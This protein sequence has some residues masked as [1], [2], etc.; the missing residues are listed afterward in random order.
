[1]S[2]RK[3]ISE[4][5]EQMN[6]KLSSLD[7]KIASLNQNVLSIQS[8]LVNIESN[9]Q[10]YSEKL[11]F[12][13]SKI[14]IPVLVNDELNNLVLPD[15]KKKILIVGFYGAPNLGDE[16][17][18][19]TLLGY[20]QKY[21]NIAIT[22][23]LSNNPD[24][25]IFTYEKINFIHYPKTRF[26]YDKLSSLFDIVIFG[27]GAHI[28]DN[29]YNVQYNYKYQ[30]MSMSTTL[31]E[32]SKSMIDKNKKCYWVGLSSNNKLTNPDFIERLKYIVKH[33]NGI[34]LR[35]S[36][37]LD[38]LKKVGVDASQIKVID[39]I[40]FAN[41][42][43]S[44]D[45]DFKNNKK[46]VFGLILIFDDVLVKN[47]NKLIVKYL[48]N[49]LE[50]KQV[51]YKINLIPFYNYLEF[52][53][54][55]LNKIAEELNNKN[56][57][58]KDYVNNIDILRVLRENNYIISL[59]YHGSLLASALNI[60]LLTI[61]LNNH[62]HY[63][64]KMEY[65]YKNYN[66]TNNTLNINEVNQEFLNKAFDKLLTTKYIEVDKSVFINSQNELASI[67]DKIVN[68]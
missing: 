18:L 55:N 16:L 23:M 4:E 40:V 2:K 1:M 31:I 8:Q 33:I 22:V 61:V 24:F 35:D 67:I 45:V 47:K 21:N 62:P 30:E 64:N 42:A 46:Y 26:D 39:D 17:M 37:S 14:N 25:N 29:D 65:L 43:L 34:S 41:K 50:K 36:L 19:Q 27:G 59:R 57:Y 58:V 63:T 9:L 32:L 48:I 11:D 10:I 52:D 7:N 5:V 38:V 54:N 68:D 53:K 44:K 20:L 51:K 3:K 6:N 60:P 13:I 12:I 56:I 66:L 15:D 28:D 49:Y